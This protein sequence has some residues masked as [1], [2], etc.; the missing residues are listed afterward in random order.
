MLRIGVSA[1]LAIV[2]VTV[3][4]TQIS[5]AQEESAC[6]ETEAIASGEPQPRNTKFVL[7]EYES[8][9][10]LGTGAIEGQAFL[11]DDDGHLVYGAGKVIFMNPVTT[12][13]TEW[14]ERNVICRVE[15]ELSKDKRGL[16]Y[17][18][19]TVADGF[20][21][22]RFEGLP[23]GDYYLGSRVIEGEQFAY[24]KVTLAEGEAAKII[25]THGTASG[26]AGKSRGPHNNP[27]RL[28]NG[29]VP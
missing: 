6:D 12:Y 26:R 25:L 22:F 3:V 2:A 23:A 29:D 24:A 11:W 4:Q 10:E 13:S 28:K 16:Y 19:I 15:L 18:W 14:W 1:V 9:G 21:Q 7:E 20:G 8:Y 5:S 17:H 27:I